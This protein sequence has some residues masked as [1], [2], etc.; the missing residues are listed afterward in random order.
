MV[1]TVEGI[2]P[3]RKWNRPEK[4]VF[5]SMQSTHSPEIAREWQALCEKAMQQHREEDKLFNE[6]DK[7]GNF[8]TPDPNKVYLRDLQNS[9]HT[10][11]VVIGTYLLLTMWG[12]PRKLINVVM[13]GCFLH[14]VGKVGKYADREDRGFETVERLC[15][16]RVHPSRSV[17]YLNEN[18]SK[19]LQNDPD[20]RI[21]QAVIYYHHEP[22]KATRVVKD[23]LVHRCIQAVNWIDKVVSQYWQRRRSSKAKSIEEIREF[24]LKEGIPSHETEQIIEVLKQMGKIRDAVIA[25]GGVSESVP[26]IHPMICAAH[27]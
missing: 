26:L 8:F 27:A 12:I 16:R 4:E 17:T 9:D 10:N 5:R 7:K 22:H 18:A 21:V 3:S 6:P 20:F 11:H 14:D 2:K 19:L 24:A 1:G 13:V 25:A 15:Y 23:P